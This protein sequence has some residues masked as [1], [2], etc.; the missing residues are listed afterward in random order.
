MSAT[1]AVVPAGTES[2]NDQTGPSSA[3]MSSLP[4]SF[5]SSPVS[6]GWPSRVAASAP[7]PGGRPGS[8]SAALGD[9]HGVEGPV[10]GASDQEH[11]DQPDEPRVAQPGHLGQHLAGERRLLVAD[12]QHLDRAH[13]PVTRLAKRACSAALIRPSSRSRCSA[14]S[15]AACFAGE[16]GGGG[17]AGR[18]RRRGTTCC[19]PTVRRGVRLGRAHPAAVVRDVAGHAGSGEL[20]G[21]QEHEA[22]SED[23]GS[24][25]MP[26]KLQQR[27][28]PHGV[29]RSARHSPVTG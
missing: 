7:L 25:T 18:C 3:S 6:S 24:L 13:H 14:S 4:G 22:T 19:L 21:H 28:T 15:W 20:T 1:A 26:P 12:D 27:L 16:V 11:V 10:G 9:L 5:R 8:P 29:L 17:G 23:Y 2:A